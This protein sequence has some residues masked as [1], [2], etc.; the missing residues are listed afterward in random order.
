M[1]N[2]KT[3]KP[4]I[5]IFALLITVMALFFTSC[6][7]EEDTAPKIQD[8]NVGIN[9]V[10]ALVGDYNKATT[11]EDVR[12]RLGTK[13]Y[14]I[15]VDKK[16]GSDLVYIE[17]DVTI[18]NSYTN[19]FTVENVEL[20]IWTL[21]MASTNDTKKLDSVFYVDNKE[22]FT[23]SSL[24]LELNTIYNYVEVVNYPSSI[25]DADINLK[26][27]NKAGDESSHPLYNLDDGTGNFI[28][29]SYSE[30]DITAVKL[31]VIED[32]TEK[33][34]EFPDNVE[35]KMYRVDFGVTVTNAESIISIGDIFPGVFEVIS[36]TP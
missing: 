31:S 17:S 1:K 36:G 7:K 15:I 16:N 22:I 23:S 6:E 2:T 12:N 32:G 20:D 13:G 21:E 9:L 3:Q 28:F 34:Y 24:T 26:I 8:V 19:T 18:S 27:W 11:P 29:Y 35:G 30:D 14:N 4:Y 10:P 25:N 5:R 33:I